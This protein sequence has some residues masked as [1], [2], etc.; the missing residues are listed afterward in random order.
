MIGYLDTSAFLPLLVTEPTSGACRRFWNDAHA[1]V[2]VRLMYVE[3]AAALAQANRMGRIDTG[4]HG[5][6]LRRLDRLW[7][8]MD[9]IDVDEPL[10]ATAADMANALALRGYDAVHCAAAALLAD[11]DLVAAAGDQKLLAAWSKAGVAT[12][13]TTGEP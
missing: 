9:V 4:A 7:G 11:D 12:Y 3:A 5:Q 2:S 13:D 8:E 1:V 10:V 6:A